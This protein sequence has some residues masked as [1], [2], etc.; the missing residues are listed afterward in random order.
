MQ[1]DQE[2]NEIKKLNKKCN[3]NIFTT[4]IKVV[5]P[6]LQNKNYMN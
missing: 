1:T 5:K 4:D 6:L 3:V 2:L